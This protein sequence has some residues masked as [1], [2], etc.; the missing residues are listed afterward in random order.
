MSGQSKTKILLQGTAI[1]ATAALLSKLLGVVYR[2]PYQNITGNMGFYVYQQV[3]PLYSLLL[4]LATAGFPIAVSK[5]VAE[6]LALGDPT[7]AKRVFKVS[8]IILS[9]TGIVFFLLLYASAPAIASWMEDERLVLPLRSVSFA[10]LIVPAMGA[11]R[12]YFQGHQNMVPTAVSQ[13]V[14]QIVRVATI[15]ILSYWF[16]ANQFDVYYAGAG[17]VFGAFTGAISAL[18]ILIFFWKKVDQREKKAE[19][20]H[21]SQQG[22]RTKELVSFEQE[23][24]WELMKK[25]LYYAIPI[26][27]GAMVLPMFQLVD[28]FTVVKVLINSGLE[29]TFSREMK[30]IFDRG[31]PLVQFAAFFA[32]ALSL[33]LVPSISEAHAKQDYGLIAARSEIAMR[34]TLFIGLAASSGLAILAGP[35]NVM[36]YKTDEGTL[37]LAVL[38]FTTVFST[39]GIASGA[40]LQGLGHVL[41]PARNLLI[42]VLVKVVL[43]ILLIPAWHITG[44]ALATVLAY[45]VAT[46]LNLIALHKYTGIQLSLRLFYAKPLLAVFT[47]TAAVWL[48]MQGLLLALP[49]IIGHER[50]FY[51]VVALSSVLVG[52]VIYGLALLRFGAVTRTEL[53]GIPKVNRYVSFLDRLKILKN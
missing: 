8:V 47:M 36:L 46:T 25:I 53:S 19:L 35:I 21:H 17:A 37:T 51:T 22:E 32:A 9:F 20:S 28:S 52:V 30:G 41:L 50:I 1:L 34:L 40:V 38:A 48:T 45:G 7:G 6:R 2:I 5:M 29:H 18:L 26:C 44:A 12:G 49:G 13:I 39:I 43:N 10:L 42:G 11:I 27:L 4:I 14:E 23:S 15:L 3:Y 24:V 33:A 16:M 31:Q